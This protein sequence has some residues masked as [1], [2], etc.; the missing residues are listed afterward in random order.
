MKQQT[1]DKEEIDALRQAGFTELT[2]SRL[3]QLR[4][5]YMT[6]E[7]DQVPL[8]YAHLRFARWLVMT[9][10][11][12]D[13]IAMEDTSNK[14]NE[15]TSEL[16]TERPMDQMAQEERSSRRDQ[17]PLGLTD[18]KEAPVVSPSEKVPIFKV[19]MTGLG[20]KRLQH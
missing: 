16:E 17:I 4:R 9:G 15:A 2:I 5:G 14:P 13:E 19:V 20:L 18:Q 8:D 3:I 11:L 12:T 10:R 7:L 1:F 6:N